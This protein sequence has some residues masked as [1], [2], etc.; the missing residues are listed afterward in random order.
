[1]TGQGVPVSTFRLQLEPR[2]TLDD[3]AAIVDDVAA[4]GATHLYLSPI[5]QA[6][7]GSS[8]GYDVVDHSRV[9]SD[10]GGEPAWARLLAATRRAGLGVVL[11]IVPNHMAVP[12]P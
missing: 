7:P 5:L 12:T 10:L 9:A 4:L 6:T 8:H 11:D 3:A 2:F 1:V